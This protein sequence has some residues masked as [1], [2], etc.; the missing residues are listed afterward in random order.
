VFAER[1]DV[2]C[3]FHATFSEWVF[4]SHDGGVTFAPGVKIADV[5][6]VSV[7]GALFIAP[8]QAIRTIEFP[9]VGLHNGVL[10]AAW[11]DRGRGTSDLRLARSTN[12]G[13]TWSTSFV[14]A[15]ADEDLQPALTT[16][17]SGIHLAFYRLHA[18]RFTVDAL[19]SSNGTTFALSQVSDTSFPG[20][21]N[22]PQF[23]PIIAQAYMGDY[24]AVTSDGT[25]RYFAWGDNR[26]VITTPLWPQA[27][28][29]P[30]IYAAHT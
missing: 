28:N 1:I 14:T 23:D 2:D 4:T 9:T 5:T 21:F 8:G 30:D 18:S 24:I 15:G 17:N 27:R 10:Y 26:D 22:F 11:N 19:D 6:P 13:V 16:D 3:S 20:V 12:G 25:R 29:D 7:D